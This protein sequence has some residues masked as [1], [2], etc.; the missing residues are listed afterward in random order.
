MLHNGIL[1]FDD[2]KITVTIEVVVVNLQFRHIE[3]ARGSALLNRKLMDALENHPFET[4][5]VFNFNC[6][7]FNK[8][9][10]KHTESL[11]SYDTNIL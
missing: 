7:Y 11:N 6:I 10:E 8:Y 3:R 2:I 5:R 4:I 9:S 1:R